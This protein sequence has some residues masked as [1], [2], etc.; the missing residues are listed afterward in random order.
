MLIAR[1]EELLQNNEAFVAEQTA[2][3]RELLRQAGGWAAS[4]IPLDRLLGQPRAAGPDHGH[5]ARTHVRASQ[6][7]QPGRADD[8]NLLSVLQYAVEVLK[9]DHVSCAATTA[10]AA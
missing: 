7:R 9:V 3:G 8:M 2:A 1:I 4:G 10:A 6:Y 5:H